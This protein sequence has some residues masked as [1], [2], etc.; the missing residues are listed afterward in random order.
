[1]QHLDDI[2]E[3]WPSCSGLDIDP[4]NRIAKVMKILITHSW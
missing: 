4:C 1:M 3:V 2:V